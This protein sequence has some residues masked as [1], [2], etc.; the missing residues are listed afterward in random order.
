[1]G[2]LEAS[3]DG[4]NFLAGQDDGDVTTPFGTHHSVDF[5]KIPAQHM[6]EEE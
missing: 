4:L 3:K 2:W 6:P 1:V 5:T